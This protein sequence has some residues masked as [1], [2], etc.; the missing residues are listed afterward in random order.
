MNKKTLFPYMLTLFAVIFWSAN[1]NVG[2]LLVGHL[3]PLHLASI[4][5]LFSFLCLIPIVLL[6]ENI[7]TI[8][9]SIQK[10]FWIYILLGLIGI[11]GYS[12]F[13]FVGLKQTTAI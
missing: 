9:Q 3:P 7:T 12:V 11:V 6:V 4:R 5:F 1:F 2:K 13:F 8:L 10:N